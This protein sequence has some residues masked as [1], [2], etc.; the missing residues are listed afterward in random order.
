MIEVEMNRDVR[1]FEPK[2]LGPFTRRQ[3]ICLAIAA[4]YAFPIAVILPVSVMAKFII[5]VVLAIP[6]ILCGYVKIFNLP[7][8]Q[9]VMS[10]VIPLLTNPK[11]RIYQ[12][13]NYYDELLKQA[14]AAEKK[15]AAKTEKQ[16]IQRDKKHKYRI[17]K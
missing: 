12:S 4:G 15:P 11:T 8:E 2:I 5:G 1:T 6:A 17:C 3:L 9:F 7:L 16:K 10:C 14:N 13:E